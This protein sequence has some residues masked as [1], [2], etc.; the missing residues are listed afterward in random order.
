MKNSKGSLIR[1]FSTQRAI[2][3]ISFIILIMG[4]TKKNF[5]VHQTVAH[6]ISELVPIITHHDLQLPKPVLSFTYDDDG[7]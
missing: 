4:T 5:V 7:K 1:H 2:Q 3:L 6:S